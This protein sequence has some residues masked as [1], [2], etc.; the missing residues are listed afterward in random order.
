MTVKSTLTAIMAAIKP[1]ELLCLAGFTGILST[2]AAATGFAAFSCLGALQ[3]Q[4]LSAL[5]F[6]LYLYPHSAHSHI[7]YPFFSLFPL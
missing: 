7:S 3:A 5:S 4:Q 2:G 1:R 6:S